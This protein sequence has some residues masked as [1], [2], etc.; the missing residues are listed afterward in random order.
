MRYISL[1]YIEIHIL[2]RAVAL[3]ILRLDVTVQDII[4]NSANDPLLICKVM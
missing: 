2:I 1:G 4:V 3:H